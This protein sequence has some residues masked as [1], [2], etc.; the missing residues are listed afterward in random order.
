MT[1]SV[2]IVVPTLGRASLTALLESLAQARGPL[3]GRILLVRDGRGEAPE[4]PS[5]LRART[6][7]IPGRGL[8]PA[9]ARNDGWRASRA[10]WIA[11]LDDDVVVP[12]DWLERLHEDLRGLPSEVAASQGQVHVPLPEDRRPTDWERNVK[13]LENA[14]WATADMAVRR[15]AL[16][17]V[18]G[19]DERFRRAYREDADLALRLVGA[20][21]RLVRGER[22]V[23]HPVRPESALVSIRLQAGN[24]DDALMRALHGANWYERA[25]AARGRRPLHHASTAAAVAGLAL[26]ALGRREGRVGVAAWLGATL[27]LAWRRIAP[28]PR[29]VREIA[30][31]IV[32]SFAIPPAAALYGLVGAVRA[33]RLVAGAPGGDGKGTPAAKAVLLDR[34]GTLIVDVPYNGDPDLV[35]PMPGARA[36]LDRLRAAGVSLAV[37]SNQSGV[38]R[39][40][41]TREQVDAVAER[42]ERLLGPVGPW[43]VCPHGPGDECGCRKPA[44]GLVKQAA[45]K[46]GVAPAE[47]VVIGDVGSDVEAAKAAGARAILV[48]TA[49]TRP[50]EVDSAPEVAPDLE[51]AVDLVLGEAR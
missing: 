6:E 26:L 36:A 16:L 29:S 51:R 8:G 44:P 27:E 46:L 50:A 24:A 28:G 39:G 33:R 48:P 12:T 21:Y 19:L 11:F 43:L 49:A 31:I 10:D 42:V 23:V 9:A 1:G 17:E 47:C 14:A 41:I 34:D 2:D 5:G 25:G 3:P 22:G 30:A 37:I 4:L 13:A 15:R 32:T 18:D 20:G 45:E 35:A 40:L 38:A 7:V